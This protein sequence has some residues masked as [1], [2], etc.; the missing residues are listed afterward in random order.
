MKAVGLGKIVLVLTIIVLLLAVPVWGGYQI[1]VSYFDDINVR[2]FK[3][4]SSYWERWFDWVYVYN[5]SLEWMNKV[6]VLPGQE[7]LVLRLCVHVGFVEEKGRGYGTITVGNI[8]MNFDFINRKIVI[9]ADEIYEYVLPESVYEVLLCL[10][11]DVDGGYRNSR[12]EVDVY[13]DRVLTYKS[14]WLNNLSYNGGELTVSGSG[15]N[16]YLKMSIVSQGYKI[17]TLIVPRDVEVS[18]GTGS[19]IGGSGGAGSGGSGLGDLGEKV[20]TI[21]ERISDPKMLVAVASGI[22]LLIILIVA[23]AGRSKV[24][25]AR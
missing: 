8:K 12:L 6:V 22:L 3:I 18:M 24:V 16:Y 13:G 23:V 2:E 21:I 7:R 11:I 25:V 15:Y 1:T 19:N 5:G 9:Y 17:R 20:T 10:V 14:E 4:V